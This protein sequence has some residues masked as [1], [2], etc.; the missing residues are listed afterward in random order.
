MQGRQSR[1]RVWCRD[2][3][4]PHSPLSAAA[5]SPISRSKPRSIVVS[6]VLDDAAS[7]GLVAVRD[8]GVGMTPQV[9][10]RDARHAHAQLRV[11]TWPAGCRWHAHA[12][13]AR[14]ACPGLTASCCP[15]P[16][17]LQP[18]A[19]QL[20]GDEP[21]HGGQ[22]PAGPGRAAGAACRRAVPKRRHQASVPAAMHECLSAAH[23]WRASV[24]AGIGVCSVALLVSARGSYS[25][26]VRCVPDARLTCGC[27][28]NCGPQLL[29]RRLQKRGVLP[30]AHRQGGD[31]AAG[32]AS[33]ARALHQ[34]CDGG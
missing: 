33:R 23:G 20:G 13:T 29:W 21:F 10:R 34:W 27:A 16:A 24:R 19:Q 31:A 18:G 5:Q 6:L 7:R 15:L 22:G 32:R 9:R 28:P 11:N 4:M 12:S 17:L 25:S 3:G 26:D 14:C 8:N 30:G 2:P 1:L